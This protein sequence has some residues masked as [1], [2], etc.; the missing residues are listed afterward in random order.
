MLGKT[1]FKISTLALAISISSSVVAL[2]Q[3]K[4]ISIKQQSLSNALTSLA[5]QTD[6]QIF[7]RDK[8][9]NGLKVSFAGIAF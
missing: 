5:K 2:E 1:T 6:I 3:S 9:I 8:V 7:A 4:T